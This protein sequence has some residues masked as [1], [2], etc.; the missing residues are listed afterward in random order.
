MCGIAGISLLKPN[1]NITSKFSDIEKYIS[2]R[3]PENTGYFKNSYLSLLHTRLSIVDIEGGNQPIESDK[4][5][6]IANGEIYNDLEIRKEKNK[7]KYITKSDSESILALY[8]KNGINGLTDLRG[9]YAFAIYDKKKEELIIGRDPFGI[10]PLYFS[11]SEEGIFFCSEIKGI[12]NIKT[13]KS[14][15]DNLKVQELMQMQYCSGFGTI[16]EDIKRVTPGQILVIKKG[17]IIKSLIN[18][19]PEKKIISGLNDAYLDNCFKE[20][21]SS[22]LRSD[23]PYCI[24]FSGGID[25]MLLLYYLK[26]L[27]K[28]NITAYSIYFNDSPAI[29]LEKLADKLKVNFVSDKFS[30]KDFWNWIFFAA[31]KIDEPIADYAILPTF[32][33]A[34]IA[35]KSFKVAITG[36]GGDELFGGYGRYKKTQRFLFN[37]K[38]HIPSGEFRNILKKKF[39]NWD[40]NLKIANGFNDNDYTTLQKFQLFDYYNWLPNNLLVKLD[41]CLMTF[42]MEGRTPFVDKKLFESLFYVEDK[43]KINKG[44]GKFFVREFIQKKIPYYNPFQKKKGF[45][46][47]INDWIPKKI[48]YL[49][50][51]LL[52]QKFLYDFFT[53]EEI[54][55]I[56]SGVR[57]NKKYSKALWHIIFFTA[58]YLVNENSNKKNGNFF[59]ILSDCK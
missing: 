5:V 22:H 11:L 32:K 15:I 6:L 54:K 9:M 39:K 46:V 42:G 44:F 18:E 43:N 52:K 45:T 37:K 21:I 20:S 28:K 41:R 36:E 27:E 51:L 34:S 29:Y 58:W 50:D 35:S 13:G 12:K 26:K 23:V 48:D 40:H 4:Y 56:C 49:E 7:Y 3:G 47:P 55:H 57:V 30:E 1:T 53:K 16:Y 17:K 19:L 38:N 25:S 59:D 31:Q 8:E 33:L 10:K 14:E 2:H 24:F